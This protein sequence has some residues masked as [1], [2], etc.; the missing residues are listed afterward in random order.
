MEINK[1]S[2][3][4]VL[5]NS[6]WKL[7]ESVGSSGIQFLITVVLARLLTPHDYGLM[8]IVL[9]AITFLGLFINSGIS[10]YLVYIKDIRKED[11]LTTLLINIA[12][13][14]FLIV[15]LVASSSWI[16]G[17]YNAPSLSPLIIAMSITLPFN[18]MSAVYNAY[19]Q[20]LSHFKTLFI[21]NMV[22]LPISGTLA[23]VMA[24]SGYGVWALVAQ[25]ISNSVLLALIMV[26]TIKV[27][28]D[29]N[30]S[31]DSKIVKPMLSYGGYTL[32]ATIIA[33]ISDNISD[34]LIAKRIS[35]KQLGYYSR[36]CHFP[37][38][39]ANIG[40]SVLCG[41][42]FPAF[43]SYTSDIKELKEKF[44]KTIRILYYGMFP[45]FLGLI[46]CSKPFV[47]ALLTE[48]WA[49]SIPVMQL[50]CL[51]FLIIPFL[52]TCSQVSLA[53]GYVK[54]RM[55]GEVVKLVFV[56]PLLFVFINFGIIGVALSRVILNILLIFFSMFINRRIMEYRY[57][58]LVKDMFNP[59]CLGLLIFVSMYPLIFLPLNFTII[60]IAQIIV[61]L[62]LYAISIKMLKIK[63]MEELK[64][65]VMA[66]VRK[67]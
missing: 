67:S 49:E 56:L 60:L 5:R 38:S 52:Q 29:G 10:S 4:E 8:A 7:F 12:T 30:W 41:V 11:F 50:I 58:E 39:F 34:L 61:G 31:F 25:Q 57:R 40:N 18:A 45:L 47:M 32:L 13:S 33:F 65:M 3:K 63:E 23:L 62:T 54:L 37:S 51:Y 24:Y 15:L 46:A 59:F 53:T 17:Y 14:I 42:L 2:G 22:A 27:D 19:A 1:L 26:F 64:A 20:K 9:V 28:I 21:R 16:A 66:K 6:F 55:F 36:G 35:P 48:K 43:A 44:R